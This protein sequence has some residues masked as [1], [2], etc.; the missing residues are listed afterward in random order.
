MTRKLTESEIASLKANGC[1]CS[2]WSAV[3][4]SQDFSAN[5]I[6]RCRF[7]GTVEIGAR[8]HIEDSTVSDCQIE[9][10][11]HILSVGLLRNYKICKGAV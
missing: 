11:V 3:A 4:V 8:C 1:L 6:H 7:V 2:D 9:D 10:D 5:D